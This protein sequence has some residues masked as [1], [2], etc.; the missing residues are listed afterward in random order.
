MEW[1]DEVGGREGGRLLKILFWELGERG[2]LIV[3]NKK[4]CKS[5]RR[6]VKSLSNIMQKKDM[7]RDRNTLWRNGGMELNF[8]KMGWGKGEGKG[9]GT[10]VK[11]RWIAFFDRATMRKNALHFFLAQKWK[12]EG[13]SNGTMERPLIL[14]ACLA[15]HSPI[16]PPSGQTLG[17]VWGRGHLISNSTSLSHHDFFLGGG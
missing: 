5:K 14:G 13:Y 6:K 8:K 11:K 10:R 12:K 15:E 2:E 1:Q 3:T 9:G 17:L 7:G 16:Y 4:N